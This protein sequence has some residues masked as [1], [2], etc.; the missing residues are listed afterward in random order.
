MKHTGYFL[1]TNYSQVLEKE[2]TD[3]VIIGSRI[4]KPESHINKR[5]PKNISSKM[6]D[7]ETFRKNSG[8]IIIL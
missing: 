4:R 2:T 1:V 5:F 6:V 8:A 7:K 3:G